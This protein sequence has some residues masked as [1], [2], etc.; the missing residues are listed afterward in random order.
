MKKHLPQQELLHS[1][2]NV[3]NNHNS[4]SGTELI[5]REEIPNTPFWIVGN[6]ELGYFLAMGR[7]KLMHEN[8]QTT[9]EVMQYYTNNQWQITMQLAIIVFTD[10]YN[11]HENGTHNVR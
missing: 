11:M 6:E 9:K 4:E 5:H 7:H 10:L 1:Q 2:S 3:E 8:V